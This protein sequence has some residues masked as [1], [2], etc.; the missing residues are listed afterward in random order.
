MWK[1]RLADSSKYT[2]TRLDVTKLSLPRSTTLHLGYT[3]A[4]PERCSSGTL[5]LMI[6]T[7]GSYIHLDPLSSLKEP[8]P[9]EALTNTVTFLRAKGVT[10]KYIRMDNQSSHEFRTTSADLDLTRGLVSSSQKEPNRSERAIQTAKHHII[11]TRAGFHRDCPHI[12]LDKE[13][14][15]QIELSMNVLRPFEYDPH[16][17]AYHGSLASL[18]TSC[19]TQSHQQD[20]RSFHGMHPTSVDLGLTMARKEFTLARL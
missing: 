11:A 20:P 4:L 12:Y 18:S 6:S 16:I 15:H 14:L 8:Q 1:Q 7:W 13:C 10:L 19:P 2:T 17:S 9:A 5:Y 3:G